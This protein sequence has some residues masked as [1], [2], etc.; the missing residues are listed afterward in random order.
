MKAI[1]I[2][3]LMLIASTGLSAEP[4]QEDLLS[5]I[6]AQQQQIELLQQ[7]LDATQ[8]TLQD[9]KQQVEQNTVA[10]VEVS[11]KAEILA[12]SLE[13]QPIAAATSPTTIGGYGELHIN[14]LEDQL[15]GDEPN[16]LDL[17]RF[18]LFF[19]HDFN[20]RLRFVSEVEI[21]HAYSSGDAPGAVELE[22]AYIEYDWAERHA[23]RAGVF[24]VPV[25]ILNE[26]HEPPTFYGVE[27][28][29]VEKNIIPTTWWEGG[30]QFVGRFGDAWSYDAAAHSGLFTTADDNYAIRPGRQKTAKARFDS[31]AYTGRLRWRGVPGLELS[32]SI[33][34]QDDITQDTDPFAGAAWLYSTHAA[35]QY[36]GFGLRAVYARWDLEGPGPEAIGADRQEGWFVEPSWRFNEQWGVFARYNA[37]DNQAGNGGDSEYTQWDVGVNYWLHPNVVF[38]LDYQDQD[39]P[40]GKKELDGWN[41]GVGYQF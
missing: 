5:L 37:W 23:L 6:D 19:N 24:L 1:L 12:D 26:T 21:E 16:M 18:V 32:A 9:L 13:S 41:L 3:A 28:N 4:N 30:L 27:R 22:Q 34:Y 31:Q 35:W 36:Q 33:Q 15:T 38:K 20:D 39:A 11:E 10:S 29:P 7:Q 17:H 14:M 25:G 2:A 8:T 40:P